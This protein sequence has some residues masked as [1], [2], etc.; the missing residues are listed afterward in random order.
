VG[1]TDADCYLLEFRASDTSCTTATVDWRV[2]E[3]SFQEG[4]GVVELPWTTAF[5]FCEGEASVRA[6]R[7]CD[8]DGIVTVEIW[9]HQDLQELET[10]EGANATA[11]ASCWVD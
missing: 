11:S 1:F 2:T 7:T 4:H 8:D 10:A 9:F 3:S 6:R 5:V